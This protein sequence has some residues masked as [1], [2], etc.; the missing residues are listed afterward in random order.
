MQELTRLSRYKEMVSNKKNTRKASLILHHQA[1][2][3]GLDLI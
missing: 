1:K 2:T 3:K